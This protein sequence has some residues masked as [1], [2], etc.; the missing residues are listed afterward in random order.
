M[1]LLRSLVGN[2]QA[3]RYPLVASSKGDLMKAAIPALFLAASLLGCTGGS[4]GTKVGELAPDFALK[5]LDGNPV[6]L[7]DL[8]GKVVILNFWFL[9]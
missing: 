6:K 5:D 9:R 4:S 3:G 7:S 8:R 2:P 1:V